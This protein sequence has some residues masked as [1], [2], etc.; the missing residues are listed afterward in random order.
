MDPDLDRC[1]VKALGDMIVLLG[2]KQNLSREDATHC[3][4]WRRVTRTVNRSN[5]IHCMIAEI[6]HG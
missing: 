6:V 4:A 2:E 3:A 1:V 5:G